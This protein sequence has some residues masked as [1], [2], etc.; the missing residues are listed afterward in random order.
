MK[1]LALY[2]IFHSSLCLSNTQTGNDILR[3]CGPIVNMLDGKKIDLK[4]E[5]QGLWCTGYISGLLDGIALSPIKVDG[6]DVL[7][8][9]KDGISNDQ[10]IRIVVKWLRE[11]PDKLH[12]S[13]RMEALISLVKS[14][15]CK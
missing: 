15:P 1:Y 3:S 6:K 9:P 5:T 7:C 4:E 8:L 2:L 11:H 12:L 14:F 10:A 13:G